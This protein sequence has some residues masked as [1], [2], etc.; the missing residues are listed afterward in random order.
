M[1]DAVGL[2]IIVYFCVTSMNTK[3]CNWRTRM[4]S[5]RTKKSH[6]FHNH[7]IVNFICTR[8]VGDHLN[9]FQ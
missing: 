6:F 4:M 3:N 9:A 1:S 2:W 7:N 5:N 8:P